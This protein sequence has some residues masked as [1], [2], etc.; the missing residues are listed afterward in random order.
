MNY[1][2]NV[3]EMGVSYFFPQV[4]AALWG[5]KGVKTA[6]QVSKVAMG[7]LSGDPTTV[8]TA[9]KLA[10]RAAAESTCEDSLEICIKATMEFQSGVGTGCGVIGCHAAY[11]ICK[12]FL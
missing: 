9:A 7:A 1:L 11:L 3:A 5:Y 6:Y 8:F 2:F 4:G 10:G 12:W